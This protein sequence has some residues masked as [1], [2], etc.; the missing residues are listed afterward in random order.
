MSDSQPIK[1]S[2]YQHV[3]EAE[4][5][6]VKADENP[7]LIHVTSGIGTTNYLVV[8]PKNERPVLVAL[9]L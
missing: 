3:S 9:H 7:A 2:G 8:R 1:L 4:A 5:K 6:K